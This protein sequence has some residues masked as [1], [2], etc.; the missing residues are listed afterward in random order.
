MSHRAVWAIAGPM[1]ISNISVPLVGAV[2]TA[3]VGRLPGPEYIG[4]VAVGALIFSFLYWGF[5][6]LR[7]GTTGYIARAHGAGDESTTQK[8]LLRVLVLAMVFGFMVIIL[9]RPLIS[10]A[11]SI[12]ESTA[13]VESLAEQ[14]AHIRVL[15]GPATLLIYVFTGVF[16]GLQ[17]TRH[18]FVL[19]IVLNLSN[20]FL[21]LLFVVVFEWGVPGVAWAT[22]I[23][24]YFAVFVGA[25]LLR[26]LLKATIK[27]SNWKAVLSFNAMLELMQTN[28]NI[29]VRTLCL[30]FSFSVFTAQS[31]KL[32][33]VVLAAN[34]ILLHFNS[35]MAYAL[36][37]FAHAA[38]ALAGSAYGA[39]NKTKF[40]SAVKFT[41]AWAVAISILLGIV[42]YLF[43]AQILQLLSDQQEVLA[44]ANIYLPWMVIAPIISVWSFQLDGVFIGVSHSREMRNAMVI[45]TVGYLLLTWMLLPI[46]GN[47]GLYMALSLLMILRALTLWFY[48]PGISRRLK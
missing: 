32:G 5:S 1:I 27:Q 35:I 6:F 17:N 14:Y 37:G 31:A 24:E 29:F 47:H 43:G 44:M 9:G 42:Y 34:T 25:W 3:V 20:V 48:Y 45:S 13:R 4:A 2:D 18:A 10:L 23:A 36:D 22:L 12:I 46:Y 11:L 38:E 8:V 28:S 26:D 19:Q 41:T 39:N 30:V 7:M 40:K 15:S 33:E 16:I 21:D